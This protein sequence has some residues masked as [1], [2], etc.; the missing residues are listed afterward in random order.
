MNSEDFLEDDEWIEVYGAKAHNLKNVDVC[1]PR[2]KLVVFTGISGSGKSSLAFDTIFAE[3]QRRYMETFSA[4][5]RQFIGNMERPDVE[6]I[7]GLSPVISIE[8]KTTN[9]NPRSTVGTTTEIYDFLRLLFARAGEAY[10]YASGKKMVKYTEQKIT[11][12]VSE[13]Y[14]NK[15][16]MILSPV[17]KGRKGHYKELF[18][19]FRKKGFLYARIDGK[20]TELKYNL[21]VD[22]Y[23]VHNIEILV[24]R[25]P[26]G[27]TGDK[28][29][30]DSLG[31]ALKLGE[32][33]IMLV[34]Q[35]SG[36]E[37]YFS[38]FLMCPD[39]GISYFDPAPHHFSFNSPNGACPV[40]NG[41]GYIST[42][43]TGRIIPDTSKSI[44]KGAIV[45]VGPQ[46][47]SMIFWQMEA[48]ASKYNFSLNDPVSEIPE[49]GLNEI[50]YGSGEPIRIHNSSLG[51]SN[52]FVSYNGIV[53]IIN[54]SNDDDQPR[55]KQKW[56][57]QY[58]KRMKCDEC[59]GFRLRKE[60][61]HFR[62][63]GKNIA[64]L[65]SM[66]LSKLYEWFG[67]IEGKLS[68]KQI[69][70]SKEI[71]KEIKT[72]LRFLLD[73]GV[74]YLSLGRTS[75][76]LSGGENQRIRLATQ[77]GTELVNVLYILDE[78]SIGLHHR[79]NL[80]L[81]NSL[82]KLRD[83]RN[84]IIV[85][86][87][88]RETIMAADYIVDIGPG[89][90]RCGGNITASGTLE[91]VLK[92]DTITARYLTGK[93]KIEVPSERRQG[94]GKY[95][96]LTGVTGNNLKNIDV[97]FPLGKLICVTGVSGSGKSSLVNDTLHPILS[98]LFYGSLRDPLPYKDIEGIQYI[99]KV[100]EVNQ[101][102]I[103]RTPRSNPSTYTGVFSDIRKLFEMLPES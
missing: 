71:V 63:G 52:Y 57:G 81:I 66:D 77:I 2:N 7:N 10:S 9:K 95:L 88:D 62:V 54:N 41:L 96:V 25:C 43:D 17:V 70:I 47:S 75:G 82:K 42:A 3:G 40:C 59:K 31:L 5:A 44:A 58:V 37:R 94:N 35:D 13:E 92:K 89:A 36:E 4:Y 67:E 55:T 74:D 8:Q 103:G 102:P 65:S 20:L 30:R 46:K 97:A 60:S 38:K 6:K 19:K 28:R 14:R 12:L 91:K 11:T 64:E 39:T 27:S 93:K 99:N 90:G 50:L 72:R 51:S 69:A 78:P 1:I 87:H 49:A 29:L 24:D 32:G 16:V 98:K 100:V 85:V 22:R 26:V 21:S 23:K 101:S 15:E 86:E 33:L 76:S 79:D 45:P 80:K 18:E 48:I 61:L 34:E 56:A 73:V 68:D 83:N 84:S 53:D